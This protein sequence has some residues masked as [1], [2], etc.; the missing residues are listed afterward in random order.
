[1]ADRGFHAIALDLP[2]RGRSYPHEWRPCRSI[3]E[4]AEIVY[5][6]IQT[7]GLDRPVL[8]GSSIGGDITLDYVAHHHDELRA[9]IPMEG[10]A[11][12]PTFPV[13]TEF[14]HP[15]NCPGWQDVMERVSSASLNK[16]CPPEKV[17]ELRWMH[18]NAQVSAVGDLEGWATHDVRGK[19]GSVSCPVLVVKGLDDFWLPKELVEETGRELPK[20]EVA[21]LERIGHYP[22]FEDPERIADLIVDFLERHDVRP[23]APA[24]AHAAR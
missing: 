3:H 4:H 5:A 18:R 15:A 10:A 20:A 22:M 2:G 12:T 16:G 24:P 14:M 8:S 7:L 11:R 1:M 17:T 19:L 9:A 13:P 6:F 23:G 21:L